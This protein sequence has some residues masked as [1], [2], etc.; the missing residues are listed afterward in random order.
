[1]PGS[2]KDVAAQLKALGE[3]SAP[4]LRALWHKTFGRPHPG[5]VQKEFLVRGLAQRIQERAY[6][7]LSTVL[8]RRLRGLAAEVATKGC[9]ASLGGLRIKP[10]TRLVREWRGETHVVTVRDRSFEYRGKGYGSLSEVAR[11]ITK[12]RWSG[13]AFFGLKH[14]ANPSADVDRP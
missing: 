7:G 12:T 3:A 5:W 11:D 1:M 9:I 10:G 8:Q 2:E 4:T 6:G 13:P 14:P